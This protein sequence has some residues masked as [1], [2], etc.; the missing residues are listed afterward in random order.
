MSMQV[1]RGLL[2]C[3]VAMVH[4]LSEQVCTI[5][6]RPQTREN[7]VTIIEP[8][9]THVPSQSIERRSSLVDRIEGGEAYALAFGGQGTPWLEPLAD[10][11]RDFA[12]DGEMTALVAN[13]ESL[14]APVARQ[15][16]RVGAAFDPVCW[17]HQLGVDASAEDQEGAD[18]PANRMLSSAAV[19]VP[20]ILLTQFAGLHALRKQE[21]DPRINPPVAVIAHS[22]GHFASA[23]L[24]DVSEAELLAVALMVGVATTIVARRRNLL[25][26]AMLSISNVAPERIDDILI[27]LPQAGD[28]VAQV[29]NGRRSVVASGPPEQLRTVQ[30]RCEEIAH[31]EK[32]ERE[33]K[34]RGGAAFAPVFELLNAQA[35]FHHPALVEAADMVAEWS[36]KCGLDAG[37]ARALTMESIVDPVDWVAALDTAADAGAQWLLAVS[38]THLTL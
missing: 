9:T 6:R 32:A 31:L 2:A 5:Y 10:L 4:Y 36:E 18:A 1:V 28:V 33:H 17:A 16:D 23:S 25:G 8:L 11:I 22:Q 27:G 13:A 3:C 24:G 20:G 38:Y 19:S 15:F 37:R 35:A 14:I 29:R 30:S 12:L 26:D 21:I 7:S 34:R